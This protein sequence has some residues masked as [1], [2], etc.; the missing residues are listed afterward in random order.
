MGLLLPPHL[1]IS[2]IRPMTRKLLCP[3]TAECRRYVVQVVW[4]QRGVGVGRHLGGLVAK[5]P[6]HHLHVGANADRQRGRRV[7]KVVRRNSA[8]SR[9]SRPG[10]LHRLRKRSLLRVTGS[11]EA[12]AR[13]R[14]KTI[15][16]ISA[17]AGRSE[18]VV[19]EVGKRDRTA[20]VR[21]H[22][23]EYVVP[24]HLGDSAS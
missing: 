24:V 21:L 17:D 16:G 2:M 7:P 13:R 8:E 9:V 11:E 3:L 6:L 22:A 20:L 14:P 10:A 23:A 19:E 1:P 4:E 12:S 5:H 18:S 15:V